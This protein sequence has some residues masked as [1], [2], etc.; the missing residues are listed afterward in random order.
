MINYVLAV[1]VIFLLKLEQNLQIKKI[2]D[3]FLSHTS[4]FE[5]KY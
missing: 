4:S 3:L 5:L 2:K 1:Y